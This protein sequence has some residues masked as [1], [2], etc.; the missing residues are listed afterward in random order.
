M[1]LIIFNC[2]QPIPDK[3]QEHSKKRSRDISNDRG[4]SFSSKYVKESSKKSKCLLLL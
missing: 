1:L 2:F 4:S 3:E